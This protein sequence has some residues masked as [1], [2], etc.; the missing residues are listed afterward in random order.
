MKAQ[1]FLSERMDDMKK[2]THMLRVLSGTALL[3]ALAAA[4][5]WAQQPAATPSPSPQKKSAEAKSQTST[6]KA[7]DEAGDYKVISSIEIG[8]RGLRVDG[9]LNKYQSD[10]NY[11]A[12]PRLFDSSFL[13]E[14]KPGAKGQ[15]LDSLLLTS[16]G[17][18]GD[19]SEE[20]TSELQSHSFISYAV[21]CLKK[22]EIHPSALA[23]PGQQHPVCAGR[24]RPAG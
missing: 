13:M 21:F 1:T 6:P 2:A 3:I 14:A 22:K 19:R 15:L 20:H 11:K 8:Y 7:G 18:G 16:T 24:A 4:T 17:W 12:G 5:A 23:A 10:L 9:D